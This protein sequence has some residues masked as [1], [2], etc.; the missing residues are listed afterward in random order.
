MA[1][2]E[3]IPLAPACGVYNVP[4][5]SIA[6]QAGGRSTRMGRDK[7]L[8]P[9]AGRRL[10][11]YVLAQV[12]GLSDDLFITTNHPAPLKDL[13]VRLVPD[14]EPGRG[15]LFGLKTAL[16]AARNDHVL[17]VACDMPFLERALVEYLLSLAGQADVIIPLIEGEYEPLLAVYQASTCLPAIE[18]SSVRAN[19]RMI[20]FF[21]EVHVLPVEA[22]IIQRLDPQGWSF[23]NINAPGDFAAAERILAEKAIRTDHKTHPRPTRKPTPSIGEP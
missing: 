1:L 12:Q 16:K 2:Q 19:Q 7:A 15:A 21:S 18:R 6:I 23:F 20:S 11:E 10:V 8:M 3:I 22:E 17:I 4:M 14:E 9:L 13:H 5:V